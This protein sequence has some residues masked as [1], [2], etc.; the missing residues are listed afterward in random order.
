MRHR[1]IAVIADIAEIGE[2]ICDRTAGR[3]FGGIFWEVARNM[4]MRRK[5]D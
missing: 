2:R 3:K 4:N 1:V 5:H